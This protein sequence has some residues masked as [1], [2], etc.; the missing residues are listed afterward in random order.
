MGKKKVLVVDDEKSFLEIIKINLEDTGNYEVKVLSSGTH[1]IAAARAFKPDVIL[2]DILMPKID[3]VEICKMFN[4]DRERNN[5]PIIVISALNTDLDKAM[6][7][8]LGIV[9]F[10]AKPVDTEELITKMEKAFRKDAR[11]GDV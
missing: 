11:P 2:L 8:K 4:E 7:Y 1:V 9:D 10:I 5:I 3:G 6:M